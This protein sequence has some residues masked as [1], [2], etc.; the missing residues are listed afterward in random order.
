MTASRAKYSRL[1]NVPTAIEFL[2]GVSGLAGAFRRT[3]LSVVFAVEVQV[4]VQ[5]GAAQLVTLKKW[6][7]EKWQ[8]HMYL[9]RHVLVYTLPNEPTIRR[10]Q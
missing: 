7:T 5:W 1:I 2:R 6:H 3:Q 4:T 9:R 8:W 10:P